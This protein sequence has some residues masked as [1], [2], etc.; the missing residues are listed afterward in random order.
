VSRLASGNLD[1]QRGQTLKDLTREALELEVAHLRAL[2]EQA[3]IDPQHPSLLP[4]PCRKGPMACI[5]DAA[6]QRAVFD[7]AIDFAIVLT[8]P[9]GIITDWNAGAE[10]VMGWSAAQMRGQHIARIFTTEDRTQGQVEQ[11]MQVALQEGRTSDERWLLGEGDRHLWG[12]C[13]MMPLH[14]EAGTHLGFM[15]ILRDRTREHLAGRAMAQ[16]RERYRLAAKATN[17]AIWDWDLVGNHVLWNDALEQAYGHPLAQIETTGQWWLSQIHPEDR[18]RIHDS[19][20]G[21]IDGQGS[22]WSDEYRFRRQDGSYAEILDRG[23]VIRDGEGRAIRMIGAMLDLTSMRHAQTALRKS[24]ERFRTVVDTIDAAFAIVQVKFDSDDKP[25]DYRFIEVNPAFARE[26]GV[27]LRGKWVTEFAPDLEPFWFETYGHVAKT[28]EPANFENYAEAFGRWFDVRATR[29]GDPAERQIGI[30][31]NDVTARRNA[32]ERLR[33]SE[34]LARENVER[35]QLALA[36]GAIIGTWHWH[37]PTDCFTVDEAFAIAF[38]LDPA[39]GRSG[40]SLEQVITTVHPDDRQGLI[41][42]IDDAIARGGAYAHQYRVRRADGHYYWIEANGRVDHAEDGTPTDFPGVL[43]NVQERR[44]IEAERD[45]ATNALR[46]L[47]DT[48]EQRVAERTTALMQAEEKLRQ[49]QK[50]EAVGQL[51]GGLAHDFNNLLAGISGSL[52]LIGAR[53]AKGRANE[54]DRY[55]H[56]AQGAVKRA[57]SLTHRLLAFSRR[58]TLDP[59]PTDVNI[60]VAGM[61]ELIQRSVGPGIQ[62]ETAPTAGLWPARVDASQLENA[63]LNL[64]INARDAMPEGGR[65]IIETSNRRIGDELAMA[66]D[67]ASGHY[68]CLSVAD[69]GTG[70]SEDVIAKA[71]DPFFTTKPLGQ[72]TGLGLSMIYGFAKQ[73]GGQVRIHSLVGQGT[74]VSIYLPRYLGDVVRDEDQDGDFPAASTESGE[75][76]LVVDDEPTVRMLLT[77]VLGDLGYTVLEAGD[78]LS[79]LQLLR[80]DLHI[81]L[82]VTDVG[83]PGGMN[84]RQLADA[85]RE[86][87]PGMRT[88]FITGYAESAALA[89]NDLGPGMQVLTKPFAV[90]ALAMRVKELM[91][92]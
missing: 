33:A 71:F 63:L 17:D 54:V 73:S 7:S 88:L 16:T 72:G 39:L 45:R 61:S 43:I 53:I 26:S 18:Q 31:F 91:S 56:A 6:R 23:H 76:I 30:V 55:L 80:S 1:V 9:E 47:N 57:A 5:R 32:Q 78:S 65:I 15:K 75:T 10:Q 44:A 86:L 25:I 64:A 2:L 46:A 48:L 38:G 62:V 70:M 59:R 29:V 28:G 27:D 92:H 82:L 83:L 3:G 52:E 84:G 49:S 77:D 13:E 21:V 89:D 85:G 20:H 67:L 4:S 11:D 74:T 42:A 51:T 22:A 12:S 34:A 19:I 90:D 69:T 66:L 58:Q 35:V 79:G 68:L 37:L 36:A 8:D 24:E 87:R 81:D 14:D 60:L 40:L 41:D 50:M